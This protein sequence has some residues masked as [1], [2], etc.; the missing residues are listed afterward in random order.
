MKDEKQ[1]WRAG[2]VSPLRLPTFVDRRYDDPFRVMDFAMSSLRLVRRFLACSILGVTAFGVSGW[3][4]RPKLNWELDCTDWGGT[5][6]VANPNR[7]CSDREP[8]WM[9]ALDVLGVNKS[10]AAIDPTAGRVIQ[11]WPLTYEESRHPIYITRDGDL[12]ATCSG[13]SQSMKFR[14]LDGRTSNVLMERDL[15]G[16]WQP[17]PVGSTI[18]NVGAQRGAWFVLKIAD[19]KSG[20]I[21]MHV[22]KA[23]DP[24]YVRRPSA[25][26]LSPDGKRFVA[27]E[28]AKVEKAV[29]AA[30]QIWDVESKTMVDRVEL[31]LPKNAVGGRISR[32][33]WAEN[34]R[35]VW[36]DAIMLLKDDSSPQRLEVNFDPSTRSFSSA[37]W[38]P[39]SRAALKRVAATEERRDDG[40]VIV[41]TDKSDENEPRWFMVTQNRRTLAPWRRFPFSALTVNGGDVGLNPTSNRAV[42]NSN[43]VLFWTVEPTLLSLLPSGLQF[44]SSG[45]IMGSNG[46]REDRIRWHAWK[47]NEWRDVG[48]GGYVADIQIRPNALIAVVKADGGANTFL[49][50]W[51]LP[52]RDPKRP[53]AAVGALSFLGLWWALKKRSAARRG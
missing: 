38:R 5:V 28:P 10:V 44:K 53:A 31:P 50:S 36:V 6:S 26:D 22:M 30:F 47:S 16:Y 18:W 34:G 25:I 12:M 40:D 52:P 7:E 13:K 49:Q 1:K 2:G 24:D 20:T 9:E 27:L 11:R 41:W 8:V 48:C 46:H 43:T 45:G 32:L 29:N 35:K 17:I 23:P 39:D 42:P 14:V 51:P 33:Y 15:P 21:E 37:T 19:V 3:L 4:M